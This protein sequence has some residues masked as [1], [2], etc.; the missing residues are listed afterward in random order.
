MAPRYMYVAHSSGPIVP[1]RTPTRR[2]GDVPLSEKTHVATQKQK[3]MCD[4]AST[5]QGRPC[6]N[7]YKLARTVNVRMEDV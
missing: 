3:F 4:P 1:S 7:T 5:T 6:R 2:D